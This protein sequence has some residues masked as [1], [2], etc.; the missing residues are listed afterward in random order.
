MLKLGIIGTGAISHEFITAAHLS[1]QYE[2]TAI[3]SRRIETAQQFAQSYN[4]PN[5]Y[6]SIEAFLE[7]DIDLVYIASPNSLHFQQ[8]KQALQHKKHVIIEKPAVFQPQQWQ[9]LVAL[10]HVQGVYL[11]EAARNYHEE[12]FN[13]VQ[14]FLKEKDILGAHFTYAKY[15][16]KM[17]DLLAGKDPNV[18]SSRFAG[19]ALMDLGIYPVYAAIK[20]FGQPVTASYQ[21]QQLPNTIDLNG[22]GQLVYPNFQV[23]IFTGKNI[24]SQLLSEIYTTDGTLTLNGIERVQSAVFRSHDGT[25]TELQLQVA[26]HQMLEEALFFVQAIQE[27]QTE[28]YSQT[29]IDSQIVHNTIY[30]MRKDA[31]ILFEEETHA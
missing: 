9:E 6:T 19:G 30:A 23:H 2:L 10:A 17:P 28:A 11:F 21:A 16:S 24:Q 14:D 27:E 13:T 25:I 1:G 15:S 5:L 22:S 7:S 4:H 31:G 29:L 12:A 20:L 18:F 3:Y 8:A 26:P